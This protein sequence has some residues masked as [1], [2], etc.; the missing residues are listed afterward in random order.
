MKQ[1][2]GCLY[3]FCI[4]FFFILVITSIPGCWII[5]Y[6]DIS[7]DV[8]YA[9]LIGTQYQS[10]QKLRIQGRTWDTGYRKKIDVYSVVK[11]PGSSEH[12]IIFSKQLKPG[13]II[14]INAIL[15]CSNCLFGTLMAVRIDLLSEELENGI[16]IRM[17][18]MLVED[19][20]G[21]TMLD[22]KFF[23]KY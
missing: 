11:Y 23:R 4:F 19:A 21:Q 2:S 15:Q 17:H 5:N 6:Q 14:K 1:L 13:S 9:H 12:D 16:P 3:G 10:L 18:T 7:S 20:N 8:K 22:P